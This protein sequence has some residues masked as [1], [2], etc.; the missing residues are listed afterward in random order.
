MWE[1][2][3]YKRVQ[4]NKREG[5]KALEKSPFYGSQWKVDGNK[6]FSGYKNITSYNIFSLEWEKNVT[7]QGMNKVISTLTQ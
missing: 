2:F 3:L 5:K 4:S 1:A 7:L 6:F